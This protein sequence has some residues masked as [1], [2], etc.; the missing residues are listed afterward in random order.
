M[1]D[2]SEGVALIRTLPAHQFDTVLDKLLLPS[3]IVAK[4]A[5]SSPRRYRF[6]LYSVLPAEL[7]NEK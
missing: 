4:S 5:F 6:E 3:K 7:R 1:S 2:G